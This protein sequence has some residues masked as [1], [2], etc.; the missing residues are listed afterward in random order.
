MNL[1]AGLA[2]L[3]LTVW[4]LLPGPL[5]AQSA[6]D[7][8]PE[9]GTAAQA[10]LSVEDEYRIG[11]MVMRGL[12]GTG[13]VLDDPE[14]NEYLQ[15]VG[16]RLSSNAHDGNRDFSFFL[17]RDPAINAFALPGASSASIPA[18]C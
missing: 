1:Q 16:L 18:C 4:L 12:R 3:L 2:G 17:I 13:Q 8:L 15:S 6:Y 14:V 10:T 9:M 5:V 7:Q 11:R